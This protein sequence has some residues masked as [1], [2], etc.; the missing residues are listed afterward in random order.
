MT[1]PTPKTN[2]SDFAA[3]IQE[4][5]T[6]VARL[7]NVQLIDLYWELGRRIHHLIDQGGWGR[8][9]VTQLADYLNTHSPGLRGFSAS[10]LW[11]MRQFYET[12]QDAP[13]K[14]APLVRELPWS[15]HLDIMGR[16]KSQEER[17]FYLAHAA[18]EGLS[19]RQLRQAIDNASFE[20][21]ALADQKLATVSR[22]IGT[23]LAG[24]FKDSYVLDFLELPLTHSERDLRKGL[25]RQL[26]HFL[27]ELGRDFSF[28]GEEYPIQVG[29]RD[30]S[31]DLLF[32]HRELNCLV[33]IELKITA[34]DPAHLGQLNFYLEAL[35][36]DIKKPHENPSIGILLC[37]S[38]DDEVVEYA[39]S[40]SLSPAL[41]AEYQTKLPDK[42]LL[43]AKLHEFLAIETES[44]TV[45]QP[46][47]E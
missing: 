7:V 46:P 4:R 24:H 39:L 3:L 20:R 9:T 42:A 28:I 13:E 26:A 17:Y 34:F 37:A 1:D 36:R 35:D 8:A 15:V 41:V 18:R 29:T 19:V 38:K 2:F 14:L 23:D 47:T 30:G 11:R 6:Q 33:A 44:G 5:R 45:Y 43:Q 10:N 25:V 21:F 31:I 32:F 16:C 22:E 40:R 12:W 27:R